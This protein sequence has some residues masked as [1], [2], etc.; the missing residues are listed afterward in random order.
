MIRAGREGMHMKTAALALVACAW[1]A[2][3]AFAADPAAAQQLKDARAATKD[4]GTSLKTELVNA[5]ASGGA[6]SAM[7]VC[8]VAAPALAEE[9]GAKH[10]LTIRRTA[11][12]VRNP[13]NAPDDW[14]RAVLTEFLAKIKAGADATKL[15]H[16]ET[17]VDATGAAEFRYMKAIPMAAEPCLTCHGAP[18]PALKAEILRLY[19]QDQATGFKAGGLRGAFSVRAPAAMQVPAPVPAEPPAPPASGAAPPPP[20]R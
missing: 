2:G 3:P 9:A 4:L 17:L 6:V 15:E 8:K 11:L 16:A 18:E 14:E 12:R 5:I 1:A 19:P 7:G 13:A 10:G 20:P